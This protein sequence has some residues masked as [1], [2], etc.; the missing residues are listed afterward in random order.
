M[1]EDAMT[2][3]SF[4]YNYNYLSWWFVIIFACVV[5]IAGVYWWAFKQPTVV[6]EG[7]GLGDIG[8]IF[9]KISSGIS[10]IPKGFNT[11]I[12]GVKDTINN[13]KKGFTETIKGIMNI[14]NEIKEIASKIEK[15][16]E[17]V[18]DVFVRFIPQMFIYIWDR[19][20]CGFVKIT[21]LKSC[22]V[23][24]FI[25]MILNTLYIIPGAIIFYFELEEFQ[26]MVI[27]FTVE[28]DDLAVE[29]TGY[30]I[31]HYTD[32]VID[33]CY[34]CNNMS[35]WPYSPKWPF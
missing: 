17:M 7:F 8:D 9:K 20:V 18:G 26:D 33:R 14:I 31:F 22:F 35:D 23:Y 34:R 12:E 5:L 6:V 24:Y 25:E 19:I 1:N 4:K 3:T 16:F 27:E 30:K 21:T 10:M 11:I 13:V 29:L 15:F 28:I 2:T 32:N